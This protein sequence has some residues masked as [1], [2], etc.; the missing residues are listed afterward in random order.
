M[1][2]KSRDNAFRGNSY[3]KVNKRIFYIVASLYRTTISGYTHHPTLFTIPTSVPIL[4]TSG[5]FL[6]RADGNARLA[7]RFTVYINRQHSRYGGTRPQ[8]AEQPFQQSFR[9]SLAC[10]YS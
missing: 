1:N 3:G 6:F 5:L 10:S 9:L 7:Q 8:M 2:A 4:R